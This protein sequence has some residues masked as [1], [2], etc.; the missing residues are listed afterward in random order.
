LV[1]I[2]LFRFFTAAARSVA[3]RPARLARLPFVVD[4]TFSARVEVGRVGGELVDA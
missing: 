3:V 1:V 2:D 4:Q